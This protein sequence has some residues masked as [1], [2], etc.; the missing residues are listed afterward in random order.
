MNKITANHK[1]VKFVLL[2][3]SF[4]FGENNFILNV[5][6]ND[7]AA[8]EVGNVPKGSY[9]EKWPELCDPDQELLML[10]G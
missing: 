3:L 2:R 8:E 4:Y 1:P 9:T 10:A 6:G 5:T 7:N